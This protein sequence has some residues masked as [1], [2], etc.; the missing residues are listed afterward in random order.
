MNF[1]ELTKIID[2]VGDAKNA[3]WCAESATAWEYIAKND[4]PLLIAEIK[5]LWE[6]LDCTDNGDEYDQW[7]ETKQRLKEN[8]I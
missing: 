4:A 7:L 5:N 2:R 3:P 1:S 8:K 6:F